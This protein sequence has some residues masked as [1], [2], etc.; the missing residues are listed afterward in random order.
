M[1]NP[2][3]SSTNIFEDFERTD[4]ASLCCGCTWVS[5]RCKLG[6]WECC[7]TARK[8]SFGLFW[9]FL[10]TFFL[11]IVC[12]SPMKPAAGFVGLVF[13]IFT[14]AIIASVLVYFGVPRNVDEVANSCDYQ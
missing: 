6:W 4:R 1:Q 7:S 13:L 12:V 8:V 11:F 9:W 10:F 5:G 2:R 14:L 3:E